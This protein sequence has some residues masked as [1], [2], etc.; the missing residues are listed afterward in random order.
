MIGP[1][2]HGGL[3]DNSVGHQPTA[4]Q[5]RFDQLGH[6]LQFLETTLQKPLTPAPT[7]SRVEEGKA[8][9]RTSVTPAP[10]I[11]LAGQGALDQKSYSRTG[12]LDHWGSKGGTGLAA[13]AGESCG[14]RGAGGGG[15]GLENG[16]RGAAASREGMEMDPG[17]AAAGLEGSEVDPSAGGGLRDA[18]VEA[19]EQS[20]VPRSII[21]AMHSF[22][23]LWLHPLP[24]MDALLCYHVNYSILCCSSL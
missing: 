15:W 14:S 2:T 7:E 6:I 12:K 17:V 18:A 16:D 22:G 13:A 11:D 1:W 8:V 3:R 5:S 21:A 4:A 10:K 23:N 19:L 9:R 20:V 24:D